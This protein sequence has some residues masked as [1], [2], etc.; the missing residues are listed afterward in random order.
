MCTAA[1]VAFTYTVHIICV[2]TMQ[3]Y[4]RSAELCAELLALNLAFYKNVR[5]EFIMQS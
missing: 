5:I 1:A 2:D 4:I 3:N